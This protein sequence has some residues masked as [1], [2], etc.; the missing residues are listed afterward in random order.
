MLKGIEIKILFL[1]INNN[2]S[3][4]FET[5]LEL[6]AEHKK[7]GD[8][9]Y[10]LRC[11]G[12]LSACV[13]NREHRKSVCLRCISR[14]DQGMQKLAID[15]SSIFTLKKNYN[16]PQLPKS[17]RSLTELKQFCLWNVNFG[18]A[19]ASTLI[20]ELRDHNFDT[21]KYK[22]RITK[23]LKASVLIYQSVY[24]TL[25]KVRP[26]LFYIFNGRFFALQCNEMLAWSSRILMS[27]ALPNPR[28]FS[29]AAALCV[30]M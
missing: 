15:Q 10:V 16:F 7:K 17:F 8:D 11:S 3:P 12:A 24:E 22:G 19:V 1:S 26:D 30:A 23:S 9:I 20:S 18:L 2:W 14:F 5:E 27:N 25:Q 21:Q 13:S 29:S 6:M 4:H 28:C